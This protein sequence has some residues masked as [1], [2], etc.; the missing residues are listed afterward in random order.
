MKEKDLFK[1]IG[2]NI[3]YYR[4]KREMTQ[5]NLGFAIG[6]WQSRISELE[7][8]RLNATISQLNKIA[9][10]LDI[11]IVLFFINKETNATS[12]CVDSL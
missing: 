2:S 6:T 4:L 12:E 7:K 9:L 11:D 8:G 3:R 5:E 10:A 1:L